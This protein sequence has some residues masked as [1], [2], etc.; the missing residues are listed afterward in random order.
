MTT[1]IDVLA[2]IRQTFPTTGRMHR[3]KILYYTQAWNATWFGK[4]L[5]TDRIEAWEMGPVAVEAWRTEAQSRSAQ[6]TVSPLNA[7][8]LAVIHSV[9]DYY[10]H[11]TGSE[12]SE[13][14]H[15]ERPWIRNYVEVNPA[16]RG[17]VKIPTVD[18]IQYYGSVLASGANTPLRPLV[19]A[20]NIDADTFDKAASRVLDRWSET[21]ALLADR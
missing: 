16:D 11:M 17:R 5:F 19:S 4:P 3:Q 18:M 10:G 9:W 6:V 14:T 12:L 2:Y 15:S 20:A 8:E 1:S 7:D 21:L 13:L